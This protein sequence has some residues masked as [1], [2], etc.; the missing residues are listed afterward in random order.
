M[1]LSTGDARHRAR[2]RTRPSLSSC[3]FTP[4]RSAHPVRAKDDG[5][6]QVSWLAGQRRSAA[7][8]GS[9]SQWQVADDS[10]RTVAGAAGVLPFP[11]NPR[12]RGTSRCAAVSR[13]LRLRS[14][15]AMQRR[16][17]RC[18]VNR[19]TNLF[20]RRKPG[21]P[22]GQRCG[23]WAPAFAGEQR[24]ADSDTSLRE[25]ATFRTTPAIR[26]ARR[27]AVRASACP[28]TAAPPRGC[29]ARLLRRWRRRCARC[30]SRPTGN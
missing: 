4:V 15:V 26:A 13:I 18:S 27:S 22:D 21:P 12:C 3:G 30:N 1:R 28:A 20:P 25:A 23:I 5:D 6:G 29:S 10:P 16:P 8:S 14:I 2:A 19:H 11:I 24:L 7:F 17:L 9:K